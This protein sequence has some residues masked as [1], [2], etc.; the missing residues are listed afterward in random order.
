ML[1]VVTTVF[2]CWLGWQVSIV[3]NWQDVR[4][5]LVSRGD[6]LRINPPDNPF[7]SRHSFL[8]NRE[9]IN[10]FRASIGDAQVDQVRLNS[11]ISASQMDRVRLAFPTSIID[12]W[13]EPTD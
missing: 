7:Y 2:G 4:Q 8:C 1:F 6:E 11:P 3:R 10:L 13:T 9:Q 12:G 5:W